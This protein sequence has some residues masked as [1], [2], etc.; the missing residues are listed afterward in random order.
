MGEKRG[1]E[2]NIRFEYSDNLN[3]SWSQ[4]AELMMSSVN[5]R[6]RYKREKLHLLFTN[7]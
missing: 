4:K 7:F 1:K 5:G 2:L 3:D 6:I